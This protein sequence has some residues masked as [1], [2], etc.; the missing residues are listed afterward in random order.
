ML[1]ESYLDGAAGLFDHKQEST[2]AA[3]RMLPQA[4]R[5]AHILTIKHTLVPRRT[6]ASLSNN[7]PYLSER[8][9]QWGSGHPLLIS[10]TVVITGVQFF[11]TKITSVY[12][13][14]H[15]N[16]H[17]FPPSPPAICCPFDTL[18]ASGNHKKK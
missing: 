16:M 18:F 15:F 13:L 1:H 10:F 17:Y 8:I 3:R 12:Y 6:H 9:F 7:I 14:I 4:M 5:L 2:S 11:V